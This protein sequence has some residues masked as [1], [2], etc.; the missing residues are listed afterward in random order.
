MTPIIDKID[1]V[2]A[3]ADQIPGWMSRRE[4]E[5]L[6]ARAV[7]ISA[8][9]TWLEI[10]V[11]VGRSW[12]C[13][14]L[15]LPTGCTLAAIDC[16]LGSYTLTA[17]QWRCGTWRSDWPSAWTWQ[18]TLARMPRSDLHWL[19]LREEAIAAARWFRAES[20]DAVFI[21]ACHTYEGTL[22]QIATYRNKLKPGG[23]LCGHDYS[24]S[25]WPGVVQAV[26][27]LLPDRL[28]LVAGT[29]L[30]WAIV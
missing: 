19:A 20:L 6:A 22:A 16:G 8:G 21:D 26:D 7:E 28:E 10:G 25:S 9:G 27:E 29:S 18:Q 5:W 13:Q 17:E 12:L 2:V 23:L 4:L 3:A 30:W 11:M 1:L 15:A 14:A 24:R